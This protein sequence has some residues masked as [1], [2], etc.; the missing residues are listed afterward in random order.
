MLAPLIGH[1]LVRRVAWPSRRCQP[2]TTQPLQNRSIG[3]IYAHEAKQVAVIRYFRDGKL[4]SEEELVVA[5]CAAW[6]VRGAMPG[7]PLE[8]G[9]SDIELLE[10]HGFNLFFLN[11][12]DFGIWE[13]LQRDEYIESS[14]NL[15]GAT[16]KVVLPLETF[17]ETNWFA[18]TGMERFL[19]R[20]GTHDR[21]GGFLLRDDI[22]TNPWPNAGHLNINALWVFRW[23]ALMIRNRAEDRENSSGQDLAPG[24]P[25]IA[26][27]YLDQRWTPLGVRGS[28]P[29]H[30]AFHV[31]PDFFDPGVVWDI[32]C[33]YWYPHRSYGGNSV[34]SSIE[35]AVMSAVLS[36][37]DLKGQTAP[38]L[39][40]CAD[41]PNGQLRLEL[42]L[43]LQYEAFDRMKLMDQSRLL[44]YYAAH[45]HPGSTDFLLRPIDQDA[46]NRVSSPLLRQAKAL[47]EEHSRR[48]TGVRRF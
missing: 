9:E 8:G 13:T 41:T 39:Q 30:S 32:A 40:A 5:K 31:P 38:I 24:K 14:I 10:R 7:A 34:D 12:P 1:D 17:L 43:A 15:L 4:V 47:N 16:S 25:L 23:F 27:M 11:H 37:I 36:T 22:L 26:T 2:P 33:P 3:L 29:H 18:S 21:V 46:D 42:N 35:I 6:Y 45:A 44:L 19:T 28:I 48:H 20:W